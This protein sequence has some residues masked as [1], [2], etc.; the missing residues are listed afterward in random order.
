MP[1]QDEYIKVIQAFKF[2]N[3][4]TEGQLV[5]ALLAHVERLQEKIEPVRDTQ[6]RKV[7]EG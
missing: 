6:P 2:Y 7:R 4:N 1:T 3:A 5:L